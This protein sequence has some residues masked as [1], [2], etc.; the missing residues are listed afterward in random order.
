MS[1]I[2]IPNELQEAYVSVLEHEECMEVMPPLG[3]IDESIICVGGPVDGLPNACSVSQ[4][5]ILIYSY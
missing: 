5:N 1:A 4:M 2:D 3:V